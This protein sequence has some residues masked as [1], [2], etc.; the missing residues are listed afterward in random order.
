MFHFRAYVAKPIYLPQGHVNNMNITFPA[1]VSNTHKY[2]NHKNWTILFGLVAISMRLPK[3]KVIVSH[4]IHSH[5]LL[6][7]H[8]TQITI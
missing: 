1:F 4:I 5:T 7:K 2:L 3:A 6:I 8:I